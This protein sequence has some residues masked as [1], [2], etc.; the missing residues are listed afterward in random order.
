MYALNINAE[1][2]RVLSAC[3]ATEHTP[4]TMPR[5]ETLP[6]GDI[7]D[8]L[9]VGSQFIYDPLPVPPAPE[10][11]PSADDILNVLLGVTGDE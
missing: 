1:N 9:Y 5:T 10:P 2:N 7:S 6:D 11:Q 8:Y 4:K 3:Y